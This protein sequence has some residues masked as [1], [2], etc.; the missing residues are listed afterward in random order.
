MNKNVVVPVALF[1]PSV[2]FSLMVHPIVL[3]VAG[4]AICLFAILKHRAREGAEPKL[5]VSLL[6]GQGLPSLPSNSGGCF[7]IHCNVRAIE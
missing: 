7:C 6:F 4:A 2:L 5:G 3:L 1:F